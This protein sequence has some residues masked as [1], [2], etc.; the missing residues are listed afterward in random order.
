MILPRKSRYVCIVD[1]SSATPE[2]PTQLSRSPVLPTIRQA[3]SV[4]PLPASP[5]RYADAIRTWRSTPMLQHSD[6]ESNLWTGVE[7]LWSRRD[8]MIVA[9]QF[10]AWSV[11]D[12]EPVPEG[13]V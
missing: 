12:K 2:N 6:L 5:A 7:S 11:P 10:I 9:R 4:E 13:T 8:G 3:S 1:R